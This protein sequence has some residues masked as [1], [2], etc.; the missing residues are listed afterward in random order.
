MYVW[1]CIVV[2]LFSSF[3]ES[4]LHQLSVRT[5]LAW[6]SQTL[7]GPPLR[8]GT[9]SFCF[10]VKHC[11]PH[12][13]RDLVCSLMCAT[14]YIFFSRLLCFISVQLDLATFRLSN[15]ARPVPFRKPRNDAIDMDASS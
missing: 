8:T 14:M 2:F 11:L 13:I 3:T 5:V 12:G 1:H 9:T 4:I 15:T 10:G 7:G 6:I